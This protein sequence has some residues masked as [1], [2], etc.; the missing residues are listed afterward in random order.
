MDSLRDIESETWFW[1]LCNTCGAFAS[2]GI[3][4]ASCLERRHTLLSAVFFDLALKTGA[5]VGGAMFHLVHP[6]MPRT[7][8]RC[9]KGGADSSGSE[10]ARF[11]AAGCLSWARL[12]CCYLTSVNA[13][14][15]G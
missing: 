1:K 2:D 14:S 9:V 3:D 6:L 13:D 4:T 5:D 7:R 11:L 12:G 8:L 10:V 15:L